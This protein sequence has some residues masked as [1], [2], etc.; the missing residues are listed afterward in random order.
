MPCGKV[1]SARVVADH[2]VC[3]GISVE[4]PSDEHIGNAGLFK[5]TDGIG[6]CLRWADDHAVHILT[7]GNLD[8]AQFVVGVLGSVHKQRRDTEGAEILLDAAEHNG[9]VR[10]DD[11]GQDDRSDGAFACA[12]SASLKVGDVVQ[13]VRHAADNGFGCF[14]NIGFIAERMRNGVD[15]KAGCVC[16][17]LQSCFHRVVSPFICTLILLYHTFSEKARNCE[18]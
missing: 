3:V 15:R 7:D 9:K 18:K 1:C 16:D 8:R 10:V 11:I 12:D 17:I 4:V 2:I 14:G 13:L 5:I 6:I